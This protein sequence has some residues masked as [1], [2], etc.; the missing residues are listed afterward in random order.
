MNAV[1]ALCVRAWL[2]RQSYECS[3]GTE[4]DNM[5]NDNDLVVDEQENF[6]MVKSVAEGLSALHSKKVLH[7]EV[8]P[9]N[10]LIHRDSTASLLPP[11]LSC[12]PV[13]PLSEKGVEDSLT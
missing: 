12:R 11:D 2:C 8:N 13:S 3:D 9:C 10:I 6:M 7:G 5:D 1:L 4:I